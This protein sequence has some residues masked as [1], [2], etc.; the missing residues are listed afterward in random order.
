ME[1]QISYL[2]LVSSLLLTALTAC[3]WALNKIYKLTLPMTQFGFRGK[4]VYIDDN[5]HPVLLSHKYKLSSKPD[6]IFKTSL[7]RHTLVEHKSRYKGHYPSDDKQM[8]AS[9]ITA[10][11]QGYPVSS[12]YLVTKSELYPVKLSY[13]SATLY[14]KIKNEVA[15]INMIRQGKK[16]KCRKSAKCLVCFRRE[17]C[18]INQG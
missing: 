4:L 6:F 13:S 18:E 12:G 10:R 11:E 5:K 3:W 16:P 17:N 15:Y 9:A 1:Y 7:F 14:R 8:Y 2:V